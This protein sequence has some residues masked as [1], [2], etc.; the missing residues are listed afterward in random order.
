MGRKSSWSGTEFRMQLVNAVNP[1]ELG[2]LSAVKFDASTA[3]TTPVCFNDRIA[4]RLPSHQ[5]WLQGARG[6]KLSIA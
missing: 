3:S 2:S 4:V 1:G 5:A 6:Y